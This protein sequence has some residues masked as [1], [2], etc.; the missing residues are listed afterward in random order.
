[1]ESSEIL[2]H[3]SA[4]CG[5]S[6]DA[7]YRAQVEAILSFQSVS[8]QVLTLKPDD[9]NNDHDY[10]TSTA[11]SDGL[12]RL[13]LPSNNTP[14]QEP[15]IPTNDTSN[16]SG[17]VISNKTIGYEEHELPNYQ[18]HDCS[19]KVYLDTPVSVIPDSQPGRPSSDTDNL[20]DVDRHLSTIRT[21]S[22]PCPA[23]IT[24]A[25]R[26]QKDS[27]PVISGRKKLRH[28][29]CTNDEAN[30]TQLG[31]STAQSTAL[32]TFVGTTF[33]VPV[34]I[35]PPPPPISKEEF[36]THITPTLKML[37]ARLKSRTY[38]PLEQTR[39]LDK[40]ERGHWYLFIN[41]VEAGAHDSIIPWQE[42]NGAYIW[43]MSMFCRF[44]SFLSEFVK[45]GRAGWGVWCILEDLPI[46]QLPHNTQESAL[47][48]MDIRQLTLK[49]YAWGEIASHIYLLLFLA[50][51]RQI[52]KMG[53]QWR[54]SRDDVVI[55]MP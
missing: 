35:R 42:S 4:P 37:A 28:S 30:A 18:S 15:V 11:T 44:W 17:I 24:C 51:E 41:V 3:I 12:S 47:R 9:N 8:R 34:V 50:S 33:P 5:V 55:Q 22:S 54:D 48:G 14:L 10:T 7:H 2:V 1:M 36:T 46:A 20:Q 23:N 21:Q 38:R 40:L 27:S 29:P 49:T 25:K 26:Y 6:D 31:D 19:P 43:D 13:Q 53:A 16:N 45:E 32:S 52:R 39:E